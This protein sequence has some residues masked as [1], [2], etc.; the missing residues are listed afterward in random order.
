MQSTS[1]RPFVPAVPADEKK[2][3]SEGGAPQE[4]DLSK[5]QDLEKRLA[6]ALND[7]DM[8]DIEDEVQEIEAEIDRHAQQS[9]K[10]RK[11]EKSQPPSAENGERVQELKGLAAVSEAAREEREAAWKQCQGLVA[12]IEDQ[13]EETYRRAAGLPPT[14]KSAKGRNKGKNPRRSSSRMSKNPERRLSSRSPSPAPPPGPR[15]GSAERPVRGSSR[16]G[17]RDPSPTM[18]A[19]AA[20]SSGGWMGGGGGGG[21]G[22]GGGKPPKSTSIGPMKRTSKRGSKHNQEVANVCDIGIMGFSVDSGPLR[23]QS[24]M[25]MVGRDEP[26]RMEPSAARAV[27]AKPG[28]RERKLSKGMSPLLPPLRRP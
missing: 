13:F 15:T 19:E 23:S 26:V 24:A 1:I 12:S 5:T 4:Y 14:P 2:Q 27:S 8:K 10:E 16:S 7:P 28:R 3:E 6:R 20:G 17:S 9:K 25:A 18:G 21:V 22:V 11:A